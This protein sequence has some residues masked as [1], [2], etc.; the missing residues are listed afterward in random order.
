MRGAKEYVKRYS[1][2]EHLIPPEHILVFDEAQ[3]AF[4]AAQVKAKYQNTPGFTAGKSEPE[5]FIDFAERIPE[6][7]VV[8]GLSG[9]GQEIHVGVEAGLGQWCQAIEGAKDPNRWAVHFPEHVKKHFMSSNVGNE[10][11]NVL[12]LD[13]EIRFH[14]AKDLHKFVAQI[15]EG[16]EPDKNIS[17]ASKLEYQGYHLRITCNLDT[18]KVYLRERCSGNKET[19]YGLLASSKDKDLIRFGPWF[20]DA[21]NSPGG[22]SCRHL[23]DCITEFGAQGLELDASLIAWGTDLKVKK[24]GWSNNRSRGYLKSAHVRNPF[25]LRINAYRVLLTRGRDG[26]VVFVPHINELDDTFSYLTK[27]DFKEI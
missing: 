11:Q 3:R 24:G 18:A 2:Q 7:C 20:G 9:G 8:I 25:Q 10:I 6:W 14:M 26:S 19:R 1:V 12:N 27:S 15:L 13:Q 23:R 5:H 4:D 17:I 16:L 21:E 22:Y